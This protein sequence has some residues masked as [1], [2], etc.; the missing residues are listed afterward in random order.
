MDYAGRPHRATRGLMKK[1]ALNGM[2]VIGIHLK[3]IGMLFR[4]LK[5][6]FQAVN[7]KA[8]GVGGFAQCRGIGQHGRK[9]AVVLGKQAIARHSKIDLHRF[10]EQIADHRVHFLPLFKSLAQILWTRRL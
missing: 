3:A 5:L 4:A 2:G 9:I 7:L 6:A 8:Q 1:D 10:N